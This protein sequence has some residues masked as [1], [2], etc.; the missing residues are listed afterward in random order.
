MESTSN[1]ASAITQTKF[2]QVFF[3]DGV[4]LSDFQSKG[5]SGPLL[6]RGFTVDGFVPLFTTVHTEIVVKVVLLLFRGKFPTFFKWG[7]TLSLGGINFC[8]TVFHR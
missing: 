2:V 6:S 5:G 8:V 1:S 3:R 4:H 7:M